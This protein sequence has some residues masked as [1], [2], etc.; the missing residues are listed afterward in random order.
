[1]QSPDQLVQYLSGGNQQKVVL[2]KWLET[3]PAVIILDEPTRGIDVGAKFEIYQLMRQ[4]DRPWRGDP[5]DLVRPAGNSG[6]ERPDSGHAQ[7]GI[8]RRTGSGLRLPKKRSSSWR[9]P[10][11]WSTR[12]HDDRDF[13]G[14]VFRHRWLAKFVR[15]NTAVVIIYTI[16][17]V[18]F[19]F[20]SLASER[21]LT[22]RNLANVLRQAAFLGTVSAGQTIVILTAGIDLSVGSVAKL[23]VLVGAIVMDGSDGNT[24]V[25]VAA[26]LAL[27]AVVGLTHA[28]VITQSACRALYRDA[29]LVQHPARDCACDFD[30]A[31]GPFLAG[32]AGAVRPA[33]GTR[34][35]CV[36]LFALLLAVMILVLRRTRFG[37]H[38]Y[39]VGGSEQ[40]ARL[41]G[42][43][44]T[45]IKY[46]VYM[47]CSMLAALTGLLYLSRM[48]VGDPV[49]GDGLELQSI[50]AV[51]LGGTSLF[52]GRGGLIGTLGGVL[53]LTLTANLLVILNV[54]QWIQ[55]LIQGLIIV[56]AVALY[57]QKGR[58]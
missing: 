25:A 45:R 15:R 28:T 7:R 17:A 44:I 50:T 47:I 57:K 24:L 20:A 52:G 12:T 30:Q 27:G 9:R 18:M 39:A 19:V 10:A 2:A 29:G 14:F 4:L 56:G 41:S 34:P 37:R 48:G 38:V 46:G 55:E 49:V 35:A 32:V 53:L 11:A 43:P 58:R 3:N 40:V 13:F 42:M 21:F 22:E 23:S 6:D 31:G 51:I 26:V 5:D 33:G 36:I 8:C 54:N 1:M 16:L